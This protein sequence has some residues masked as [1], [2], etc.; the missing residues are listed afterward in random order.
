MSAEPIGPG[1][2]L[3]VVAPD[4]LLALHSIWLCVRVWAEGDGCTGTQGDRPSCDGLCVEIDGPRPPEV[5]WCSCAFRP[6]SR[7]SDFE[8]TLDALK[9]PRDD[10]S[11][12]KELTP[13]T[14]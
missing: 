13:E 10:V 8:H 3:E 7:R 4:S 9:K 12:P 14:A 11:A 2:F 1:D 6:I 5:A